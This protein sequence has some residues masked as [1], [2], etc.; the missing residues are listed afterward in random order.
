MEKNLL[1]NFLNVDKY[2]SW[3]INDNKQFCLSRCFNDEN[4]WQHLVENKFW[5]K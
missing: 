5:K 2:S 3:L 4:Y 1:S